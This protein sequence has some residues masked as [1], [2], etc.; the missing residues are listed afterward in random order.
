MR[1]DSSGHSEMGE[2]FYLFSWGR[3]EELSRKCALGER[4]VQLWLCWELVS[5]RELQRQM[6]GL[7][8]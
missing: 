8:A 1:S 3:T 5:S 6:E 4:K 7:R 2:Y